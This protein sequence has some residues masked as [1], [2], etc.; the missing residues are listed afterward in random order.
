M[1]VV[2]IPLSDYLAS[3]NCLVSNWMFIWFFVIFLVAIFNP[4]VK[5][6]MMLSFISFPDVQL[7]LDAIL[8]LVFN[9]ILCQKKSM[10]V[11]VSTPS[12]EA[13]PAVLQYCPMRSKLKLWFSPDLKAVLSTWGRQPFSHTLTHTISQTHTHI[14]IHRRQRSVSVSLA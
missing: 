12:S 5:W 4:F 14:Q 11:F 13:Q 10:L 3:S 6:N 8:Q 9:I 1:G 2:D 7:Q